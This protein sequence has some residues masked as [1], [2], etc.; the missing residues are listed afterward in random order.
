MPARFL[1]YRPKQVLLLSTALRKRRRKD[2]Q[3]IKGVNRW[4]GWR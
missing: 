3:P 2:T 1:P 4:M